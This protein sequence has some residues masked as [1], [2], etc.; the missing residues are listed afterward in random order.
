MTL[1][2]GALIRDNYGR[3]GIVLWESPPPKASW[4]EIQND[5]RMRGVGDCR[6]WSVAPLSG[7]GAQVPEP[8]VEYVRA[9]SVQDALKVASEHKMS[10]FTLVKVFPGLAELMPPPELG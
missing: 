1:R 5:A 6:W 3:L 8:L 4:L 10:Y 7:G 9:A 2:P